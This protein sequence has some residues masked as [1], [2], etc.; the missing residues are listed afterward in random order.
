MAN[1]LGL[2]HLKS[3][4]PP[5]V[6]DLHTGWQYFKLKKEGSYNGRHLTPPEISPCIGHLYSTL[7][8]LKYI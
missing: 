2:I 4:P 3:I 6:Q 8:T 1:G 7:H 5:L